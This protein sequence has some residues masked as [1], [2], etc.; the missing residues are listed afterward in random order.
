MKAVQ[1]EQELRV[2]TNAIELRHGVY[3]QEVHK[4]IF[5]GERKLKVT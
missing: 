3:A 4:N 2:I 5:S 1:Q